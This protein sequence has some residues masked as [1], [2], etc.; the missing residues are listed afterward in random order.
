MEKDKIEKPGEYE[1]QNDSVNR[2][3]K[4]DIQRYHESNFG[5]DKKRASRNKS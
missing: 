4:K 3:R 1:I 2:E 5:K